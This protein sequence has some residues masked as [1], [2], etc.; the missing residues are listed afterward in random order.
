MQSTAGSKSGFDMVQQAEKRLKK[1]ET[2]V[3]IPD[4][5][6]LLR[7]NTMMLELFVT[8]MDSQYSITSGARQNRHAKFDRV[9]EF[10]HEMR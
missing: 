1:F 8:I 6:K 4:E 2:D 9:Y 7:A 3:E 5:A 10:A